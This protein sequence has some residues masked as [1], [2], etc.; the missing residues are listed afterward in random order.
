MPVYERGFSLASA[1][2]TPTYQKQGATYFNVDDV[3][4]YPP[5]KAESALK[6]YNH[7]SAQLLAIHEG[8][9]GHCLQ[10]IYNN[11]KSPDV[12]RSVFTNGAM[13]EG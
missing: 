9:Q 11:K 2:F 12:L 8:V 6:E 1:E 3:S 10:G 13:I 7:Y 5:A 4:L